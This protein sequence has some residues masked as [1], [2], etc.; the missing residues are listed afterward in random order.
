MRKAD[1]AKQNTDIFDK[2]FDQCH[3]NAMLVLDQHGHILK[4]NNAFEDAFGFTEK[5]LS[6]KHMRVLF[7]E[8]DQK[9]QRPEMELIVV[10]RQ[11]FSTDHNYSMHKNGHP[12]WVSGESVWVPA[13]K[14]GNCIIKV[15]QNIH[16]QKLQEKFLSEANEFS[17]IIL[18]NIGDA[19]LVVNEERMILKTNASLYEM[20]DLTPETL[21]GTYLPDLEKSQNISFE[22]AEKFENIPQDN[23]FKKEFQWSPPGSNTRM[24]QLNCKIL[25]QQGNDRKLLILLRDVTEQR[26]AEQQREDFINFVSHELRN[27]MANVALVLELLNEFMDKQQKEQTDELL[28]KANMN[29][30]RLNQVISELHDSTRA[31]TGNLRLEKTH[32]NLGDMIAEATDTVKLLYPHRAISCKD[33]PSTEIYADRFR[34]IQVL[35]NYLTNAMKYAASASDVIVEVVIQ[36]GSLVISVSDQGPGIPPDQ[37]PHL[38]NK[39]YRGQSTAKLDGLGLGLYVCKEIIAAHG[40]QVWAT[41]Q[42]RKGSTFFFSIPL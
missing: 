30:K 28:R 9:A 42:L 37:L 29:L 33:C 2:L 14:Y 6:G 25:N 26:E 20:F 13:S 10:K 27:P 16:A 17:S 12:I 38:F 5:D 31:A 4:I 39:Y 21:E 3:V 24:L 7:T 36:N 1:P 41:S 11:G 8:Q 23:T 40:G 32:F 22:I 18:E 34:L 15:I 19:M 35:N